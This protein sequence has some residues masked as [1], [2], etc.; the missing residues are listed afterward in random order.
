MSCSSMTKIRFL[1]VAM[2]LLETQN[3]DLQIN[4]PE[5]GTL[6]TFN[7]NAVKEEKGLFSKMTSDRN[8]VTPCYTLLSQ[9]ENTSRPDQR[10]A[11]LS[12]FL[13]SWSIS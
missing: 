1:I 12:R 7:S 5:N 4:S 9:T 10:P 3:F 13:I 11:F 2:G 8:T 6:P